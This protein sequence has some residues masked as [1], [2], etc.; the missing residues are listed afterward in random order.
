MPGHRVNTM[1][2]KKLK[3]GLIVKFLKIFYGYVFIDHLTRHID[4]YKV[5]D[6]F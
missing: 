4:D 2:L 1:V 6:K 3:N 5:G